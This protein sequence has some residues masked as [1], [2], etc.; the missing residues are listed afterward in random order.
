MD[1]G[2]IPADFAAANSASLDRLFAAMDHRK[3]RRVF[4]YRAANKRVTAFV[5]PDRMLRLERP[6]DQA[7]ALLREVWK[8]DAAWARC[9]GHGLATAGVRAN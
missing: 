3:D 2:H 8:P 9:I 6:V 5:G 7:F 4:V 1:Y